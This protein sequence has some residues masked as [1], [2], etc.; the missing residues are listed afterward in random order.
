MSGKRGSSTGHH[1]PDD[2][3]NAKKLQSLQSVILNTS[4]HTEMHAHKDNY[5]THR[6]ACA[7]MC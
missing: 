5:K 7:N 3:P 6:H 2:Q 1:L 4:I